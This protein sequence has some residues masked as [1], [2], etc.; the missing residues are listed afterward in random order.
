VASV[1]FIRR[2]NIYLHR[3]YIKQ[4]DWEAPCS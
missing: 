3:C 2:L 4:R 1:S